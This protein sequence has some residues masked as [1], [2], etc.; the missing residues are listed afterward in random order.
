MHVNTLAENSLSSVSDK[1]TQSAD[2]AVIRG[3]FKVLNGG[4]FS[5]SDSQRNKLKVFKR[6]Q[7]N[8]LRLSVMKAVV[9]VIVTVYMFTM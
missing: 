3:A 6:M 4:V 2:G 5:V 7:L 1:E 8:I 9:V